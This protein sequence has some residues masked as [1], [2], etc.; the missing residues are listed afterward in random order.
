MPV[1]FAS[2]ILGSGLRIIVIIVVVLVLQ[3]VLRQ[4]IVRV[5]RRV[6]K[7]GP[8]QSEKEER[9]REDTIISVF[10][11]ATAV[12]LWIV[13]IILIIGAIGVNIAA[14]ATGA[15]LV[16]VVVGFGAQ[17]TISDYLSG[18]F[19]IMENQFRVGDVVE[20]SGGSVGQPVSG[21]VE[22]ISIRITRLRDLDGNLHVVRN[23]QPGQVNNMTSSW[24]RSKIDLYV[25]WDTDLTLVEKLIDQVGQE[26]AKDK[27]WQEFI[28]EPIKFYRV[29]D[30]TDSAVVVRALGKTTPIYQWAVAGEFRRRIKPVFDKHGIERPYPQRVIHEAKPKKSTKS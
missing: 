8:K 27:D 30:F 9:M 11:T 1:Y 10:R 20:F 14:L 28:I 5:V 12:I 2:D 18:V 24:S 21:I 25:G 3:V 17:N 7:S 4:V 22:D 19:I 29:N 13:G 23:G 6:I 26:I 16:G 15:G